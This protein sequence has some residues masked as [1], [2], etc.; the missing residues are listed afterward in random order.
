[1]RTEP[2]FPNHIDCINAE[3]LIQLHRGIGA[4]AV[5]QHQRRLSVRKRQRTFRAHGSASANDRG[6]PARDRENGD[7]GRLLRSISFA[8][9]NFAGM[10]FLSQPILWFFETLRVFHAA[11]V[12]T[13]AAASVAFSH[14]DE[15]SRLEP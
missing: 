7:I 1:M 14:L 3:S 9:T 2:W 10:G 5:K 12:A 15:T 8:I 6:K 11:T 4:G 13:W